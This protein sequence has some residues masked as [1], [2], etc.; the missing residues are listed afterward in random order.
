MGGRWGKPAAVEH[1]CML[2]LGACQTQKLHPLPASP[3]G[4]T[5]LGLTLAIGAVTAEALAVGA[6]ATEG[7]KLTCGALPAA[8]PPAVD[9]VAAEACRAGS[10]VE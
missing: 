1:P 4:V 5:W 9:T 3:Q 2:G 8:Q 6:I 10:E 7:V